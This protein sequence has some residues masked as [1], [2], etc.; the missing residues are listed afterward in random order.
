MFHSRHRQRGQSAWGSL[1][2]IMM[3]L[4]LVITVMKLW[5]AYYNDYSIGKVVA[6]MGSD[7]SLAGKSPKEIT[8]L[9]LRRLDVNTVTLDPKE[10][11]VTKDSRG[12]HV[13]VNYERRVTLFGNLDGVARFSHTATL[14][15]GSR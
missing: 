15:G 12:T 14:G 3:V 4:F 11:K 10:I 7:A 6:A 2:T 1:F 13:A 8:E 9:L 5:G